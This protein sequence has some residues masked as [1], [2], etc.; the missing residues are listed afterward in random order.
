MGILIKT[1]LL[2]FL[3]S[4]QTLLAKEL[5]GKVNVVSIKKKNATNYLVLFREKS[6]LYK[7]T[8]KHIECLSTSITEKKP[9]LIKWNIKTLEILDCKSKRKS[10]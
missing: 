5:V 3:L 10:P 4:S 1:V 8:K 7:S 6:A 9:I 2:V